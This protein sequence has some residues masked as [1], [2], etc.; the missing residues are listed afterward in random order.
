MSPDASAMVGAD[1]LPRPAVAPV[2]PGPPRQ[3]ASL[4]PASL[5]GAVHNPDNCGPLLCGWSNLDKYC[6]PILIIGYLPFLL[7]SKARLKG[8]GWALKMKWITRLCCLVETEQPAMARPSRRRMNW[9]GSCSARKLPQPIQ[10][11]QRKAGTSVRGG[12][13]IQSA[14]CKQSVTR[15]DLD[16]LIYNERLDQSTCSTLRQNPKI[17]LF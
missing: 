10:K 6:Q 12:R 15:L 16:N 7:E 2:L 13:S 1:Q 3:S 4:A 8:L 11:N 9:R 5:K 17:F 14:V